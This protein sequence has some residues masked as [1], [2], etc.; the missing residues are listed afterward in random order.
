MFRAGYREVAKD[1]FGKVIKVNSTAVEVLD[2]EGYPRK[3]NDK[4]PY[5]PVV[6]MK[7]GEVFCPRH[8]GG[9]LVLIAC[10]DGNRPGGCVLIRKIIKDGRVVN[11]P[12]RVAEA[13]GIKQP[14]TRGVM[15]HKEGVITLSLDGA[16]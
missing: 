5:T 4:A 9:I 15:A 6:T 13:L 7:P 1:L 11:G 16:Q 2:A 3:E 14:G 12:G 8:R 10:H